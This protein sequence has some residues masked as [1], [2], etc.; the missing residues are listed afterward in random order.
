VLRVVASELTRDRL[1]ALRGVLESHPG[2]CAVVLR[3]TLPG[4]SESVLALP[5]AK[6]VR[7]VEP[8]LRDIDALFGRPVTELAL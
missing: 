6:G 4:E 2:D 7:P 8:L 1:L 5:D 3:L